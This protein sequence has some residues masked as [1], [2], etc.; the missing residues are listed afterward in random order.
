MMPVVWVADG[1]N[2]F[3]SGTDRAVKE[4]DFR[5]HRVCAAL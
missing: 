2:N 1:E 4:L 3:F 5:R